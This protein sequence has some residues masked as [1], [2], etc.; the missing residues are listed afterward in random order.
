M[1]LFN[2]KQDKQKIEDL[3]DQVAKLIQEL[4]IFKQASERTARG[5][6]RQISD[7]QAENRR[8]IQ[9]NERLKNTPNMISAAMTMGTTRS[10]SQ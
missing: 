1:G 5:L 7:L 9:E 10:P 3:N 8:L 2:R 6:K 4:Q